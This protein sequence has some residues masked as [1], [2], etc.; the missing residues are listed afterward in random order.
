MTRTA[1]FLL[2]A[3]VIAAAAAACGGESDA[4]AE[5]DAANPD[6][7]PPIDAPPPMDDAAVDAGVDAGPVTYPYMDLDTGCAPIFA[8][9]IVT[10]YHLTIAP[11][12]WATMQQEF[13]NPQ[14]TPG[15]SIIE[16]PY[17]PTM[18]RIMQ[19]EVI[20]D[21]IGV[22]IRLNGN[23]SWLQAIAHDDNPK[24]QFL[25]AFNKVDPDRRFQG[26]RK[27]KLDMPRG[28]W[29]YLQQ[30]VGLAWMRGRA[31][32]PAQCANSARVFIN[33]AYYGLYTNLE[34]QDKSFLKRVYGENDNDG[35]LWKAGRDI[36]TNE[37][38]FTWTRISAW[39]DSET[40]ASLDQWNDLDESMVEWASEAVIGDTD[41]YNQ[42]RPNFYLYDRPSTQQFV[43]LANDLDTVLDSDF[44]P[45]TTTP[46]LAPTPD[47]ESRWERD[48]HHYL[49]A[50]N[51]P[52]GVQRYVQAMS[53]QLPKLDPAEVQE[54][55]EAWSAQIADAAV[56]D[57]HRPFSLED[58]EE[59]LARMKSYPS[60]RRAY[61]QTWLD[62]WNGGGADA[63]G[64]TFDMCRD[65]DD[66]DAA[67]SPAA[68]EVCDEIDNNCDGRVD[69]LAGGA[70]C[71]ADP[72]PMAAQREAMWRRVHIDI[73]ARAKADRLKP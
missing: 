49:I 37:E 17:H 1:L 28:D 9:N 61:L 30:R 51:D 36:K 4:P 7:A 72:D 54:W 34:F 63:D 59:Q 3:G 11:D 8:Q 68:A 14:F 15:G 29:T 16:P 43:W 60:A 64:D 20:H 22:M 35:D 48:W 32:I 6:G 13:M 19:G 46:V 39:W 41:G 71:T 50:L 55:V 53:Q 42:G 56:A 12:V 44:L 10:E 27:V 21:P 25:V 23:T 70:T 45:P 62:C 18:L 31:G 52:A 33:G 65:C 40:L 57:P 67:Q 58:H 73:K 2:M 69:N 26:L 66:H 47:G 38:T 24:M 5:D